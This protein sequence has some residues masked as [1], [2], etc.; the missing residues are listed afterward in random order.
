MSDTTE[1]E[2]ST[3]N[4]PQQTVPTTPLRDTAAVELSAPTLNTDVGT[5]PAPNSDEMASMVDVASDTTAPL[6]HID[7]S[8]SPR[9]RNLRH[10]HA[11]EGTFAD[12]YDSDG[13]SGPFVRMDEVEGEQIF[14]EI[15][16]EEKSPENMAN[17]DEGTAMTNDANAT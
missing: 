8:K 13:E 17:K 15:E 14:E 2:A 9:A 16:L 12:G 4:R 1:S 5:K 10:I 6:T 7:I 11:I 3:A